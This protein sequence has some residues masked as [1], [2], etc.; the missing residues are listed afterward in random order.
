MPEIDTQNQLAGA[1]QTVIKKANPMYVQLLDITDLHQTENLKKHS[2]NVLK[3]LWNRGKLKK[4]ELET[5]VQ[6]VTPRIAAASS[7]ETNAK[8][9]STTPTKL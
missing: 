7:T 5:G 9:Q 8:S 2:I 3:Y 1:L 6:I 4:I